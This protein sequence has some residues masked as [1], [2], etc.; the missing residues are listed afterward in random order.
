MQQLRG[1]KNPIYFW[2]A[3]LKKE[4]GQLT[5][6]QRCQIQVCLDNEQDIVLAQNILNNRP[7]KD[8]DSNR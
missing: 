8:L 4:M 1:E 3:R 6:G 5:L 2:V 7:R